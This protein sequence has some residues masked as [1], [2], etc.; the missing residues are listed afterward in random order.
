MALNILGGL[1]MQLFSKGKKVYDLISEHLGAV[2]ECYNLYTKA[3]DQLIEVG[4]GPKA[5]ELALQVDKMESQADDARH[6]IIK[7]FLEGVLLPESRRE[8]LKMIEL[9]DEIANKAESNIRAIALQQLVFPAEIKTNITQMN[10]QTQT[11]LAALRQVI[12]SLFSNFE[13]Q[14]NHEELIKISELESAIDQLEEDA[15]KKVYNSKLGLAEKYQLR[16]I[17]SDIADISDIVEDIS[18][19]IEII[20]V[21]RKV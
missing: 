5:E 15:I 21:L 8:V 12:E 2:L 18:D 6:K 11:Q 13:S 3:I 9:T 19:M 14:V 7:S 10:Q 4:P 1:F 20:M 17:I 16:D